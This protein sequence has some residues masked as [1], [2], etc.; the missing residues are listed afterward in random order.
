[1]SKKKKKSTKRL[2]ERAL[3]RHQPTAAALS[4]RRATGNGFPRPPPSQAPSQES[5]MRR[6][7]LPVSSFD[8]IVSRLSRIRRSTAA[9]VSTLRPSALGGRGIDSAM[10]P[11]PVPCQRTGDCS[12]AATLTTHSCTSASGL[13]SSQLLSSSAP[14]PIPHL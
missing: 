2:L 3:G 1:L 13:H 6:T 10:P 8:G 7:Q 14:S 9:A 5:G 11:S 12:L 4:K